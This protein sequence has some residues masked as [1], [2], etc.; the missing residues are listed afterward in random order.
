MTDQASQLAR[1]LW[2]TGE[3]IH[4]VVYF[5]QE[6]RDA[7]TDLG[8]KGYWMGYF[9]GR[10]HPFGTASPE[11]VLATFYGF[12][13]ALVRRALPDAWSYAAPEDVG[14]VRLAAVERALRRLLGDLAD[15]PEVAEAARLAEQATG[16]CRL[17]GRPL[18]AAWASLPWPERP[19]ERL[20]HALTLL[21]EHRGDVHVA[22]N[23][24][25]GLSG[26]EAN[27]LFSAEGRTDPTLLQ[28]ARGWTGE[29]WAAAAAAL[30]E[31]GLL[32]G[33]GRPT[34]AG[35]QLRREIEATTDRLAAPTIH[36]V[37]LDGAQRLIELLR[38]L[39]ERVVGE[40]GILVPNP[41]GLPWPPEES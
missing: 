4:A 25:A 13:P 6:V 41:M 19:L 26:L 22:A 37:G 2:N 40:G 5:A 10:A 7:C 12:A 30:A 35:E 23:V 31:R 27:V 11:V 28:Q 17:G 16:G 9:A 39:S 21:R 1:R 29:E 20:W 14:R 15:G 33:D 8:L 38:P 34:P 32:D 3:P 36:A 24:A 18:Y